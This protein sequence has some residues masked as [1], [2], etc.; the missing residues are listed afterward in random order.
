MKPRTNKFLISLILSCIIILPFITKGQT[1]EE[2]KKQRSQEYKQYVENETKKMQELRDRYD[3][4][5]KAREQEFADYISKEWESYEAF[6]G[7]PVPVEP[8]PQ[9]IPTYTPP[10]QRTEEPATKIPV[11]VK[12]IPRPVEQPAARINPVIEKIPPVDYLKSDLEFSFYGSKIML[13][14]DKALVIP[15]PSP[16]S[17]DGIGLYWTKACK[18]NFNGLI[19]QMLQYKSMLGLNDWGYY[20]LVRETS[21]KISMPDPNAR[22]LLTW[23]LLTRSGYRAKIS[24]AENKTSVIIPSNQTIYG[25]DYLTISQVNYYFVDPIASNVIQT[26]A[27]DY[28]DATR[29]FDFTIDRALNLGES[30][31]VKNLSFTYNDQPHQVK[32]TINQNVINFYKDYPL[33]DMNVYFDAAPERLAAESIGEALLP[34]LTPM[35]EVDK[36]NCLLRFVQTAFPY[37]VDQEQFGR[38][39]Y[40]FAEELFFYPYSDCEDRSVL[41]SYLVSELL[42]MKVIGLGFDGHVAT[43]V[44]FSD[45]AGV[46]GAYFTFRNEKF[47]IADPTFINAPAGLA[48]PQYSASQAEIIEIAKVNYAE[49]TGVDFRELVRKAGGYRGGNQQDMIADENGNVYITGYYNETFQVGAK[50]LTGNV[51]TR[52]AFAAKFN[53]YGELQWVAAP[54]GKAVTTGFGITQDEQQNVIVAGSFLGQAHFAG[55]TVTS[56]QGKPDVFVAKY[57]P[58]GHCVWAGQ[59]SLDTIDQ[60]SFLKYVAKFDRTGKHLATDLFLENVEFSQNGLFTDNDGTCYLAGNL[61]GTTGF[62]VPERT[63]MNGGEVDFPSMIKKESDKLISQKVER[64]IAAIFAVTSLIRS[65]GMM[66]PGQAA[67]QALDKYQPL[68]RK[69]FPEL[70]SMF[71]KITFMKNGDGIVT[72]ATK[73]H[74]T[75]YYDKLKISDGTQIKIVQLQDGNERLD[76]LSGIKVGKMVIWFSLNYIQMDRL[77]GNLL[78]DYDSSHMQLNMNLK[79][80]IIGD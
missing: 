46:N 10:P 30:P 48:M 78:F 67:Q 6:K 60:Q 75:I 64:N 8:K 74:E 3:A 44:H 76:I 2:F 9:V 37:K 58:Q 20:Q 59:A 36:V 47:I 66:I 12:E 25:R 52:N 35:T 26:Y 16:V 34:V 38:E 18:A 54:T 45:K 11:K 53:K 5:V 22:N 69:Q 62:R 79:E 68:F 57:D 41:F 42:G 70:Y 55:Y 77:T 4:Y 71:G 23:F 17:E 80:D 13:D 63:F 32:V 15:P 29:V 21:N 14:Y 51:D 61:S 50:T 1:F 27:R 40:F 19:N 24:F 28:P 7:R 56:K 72:L 43:A 31:L 33:V 39:K 73:D 49:N 65:N